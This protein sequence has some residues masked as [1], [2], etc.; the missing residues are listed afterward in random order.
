MSKLPKFK[1]EKQTIRWFET[2]DTAPLMDELD[3]VHE[4]LSVRRTRPP[5]KPIGLRLRID[6]LRAIKQTAERRGIP[7][8]S[9]IQMW[10]VEKLNQESPDLMRESK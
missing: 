2:H 4:H 1:N 6:Y 8:Q 7:Y 5:K 9:L 10:L 3:Q